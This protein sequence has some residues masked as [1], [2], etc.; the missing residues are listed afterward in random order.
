MDGRISF[1]VAIDCLK[2]RVC[3]QWKCR[4]VQSYMISKY[5][6]LVI[7]HAK[8]SVFAFVS[9]KDM[10]LLWYIAAGRTLHAAVDGIGVSSVANPNFTGLLEVEKSILASI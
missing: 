3:S 6:H 2:L 9:G 4:K 5:G 1:T 10:T 8:A 7:G